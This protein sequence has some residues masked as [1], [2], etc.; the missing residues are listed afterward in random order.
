MSPLSFQGLAATLACLSFAAHVTAA[1]ATTPAHNLFKREINWDASCTR[2]IPNDPQGRKYKDRAGIAF[3]DA[4]TMANS[5]YNALPQDGSLYQGNAAF[6]HYFDQTDLTQVKNMLQTIYNNN[7]PSTEDGGY[8]I[9]VKCGSDQDSTCGT[10]S[11]FAST[12]P[13]PGDAGQI[14]LCD[15]FFIDWGSNPTKSTRY[16]LTSKLFTTKRGGWCQTGEDFP[17]FEIAGL[18]VLH[19]MTHMDII[20]GLAGLSNRPDTDEIG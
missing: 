13:R 16:D 8:T 12:N 4:A 20:G 6:T 11:V 1:P 5:I 17:F 10:S 3:S 7:I 14:V 15:F 19:E 2:N 18:T 9:T